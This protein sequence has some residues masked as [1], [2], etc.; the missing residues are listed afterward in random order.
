MHYNKYSGRFEP[1]DEDFDDSYF[2]VAVTVIV[3]IIVIAIV[4]HFL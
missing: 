2:K 4:R 1:D 3:I